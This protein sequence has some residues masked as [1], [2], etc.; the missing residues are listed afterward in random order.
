MNIPAEQARETRRLT[1]DCLNSLLSSK[2]SLPSLYPPPPPSHPYVCNRTLAEDFLP[3]LPTSPVDPTDL[4]YL[5]SI[6]QLI[7]FS[8]PQT[9]AHTLLTHRPLLSRNQGDC[10]FPIFNIQL[11]KSMVVANCSQLL[12][13][14][15]Y[16][17]IN[18]G[19]F[20]DVLLF[21]KTRVTTTTLPDVF[22]TVHLAK[23]MRSL[24]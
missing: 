20:K 19:D 2:P 21:C 9:P 6:S 24:G 16:I 7:G 22:D 3:L 18:D 23:S 4:L 5:T 12:G 17:N 11:D 14:V 8:Q 15:R 13:C 10:R 1:E